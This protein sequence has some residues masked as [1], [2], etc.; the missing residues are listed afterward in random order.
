MNKFRMETIERILNQLKHEIGEGLTFGDIQERIG[1]KFIVCIPYGE[2]VRFVE[3]EFRTRPIPLLEE[4]KD[5][6][7]AAAE[8]K[9]L[10]QQNA[11]LV[12]ALRDVLKAHG[13]GQSGGW[14]GN[15]S[16]IAKAQ[17]AIAKATG[18]E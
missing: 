3:G 11:E 14:G 16:W 4:N 15:G 6:E 13:V 18:G 12:E 1:F 17:A 5:C 7:E 9:E 8:I 2:G 10:R